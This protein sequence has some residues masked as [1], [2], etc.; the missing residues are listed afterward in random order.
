M[1]MRLASSIIEGC[2][3]SVVVFS[4]QGDHG[5]GP[6]DVLRIL[7][8]LQCN[9]FYSGNEGRTTEFSRAQQLSDQISLAIKSHGA[10]AAAELSPHSFPTP[11][12][13]QCPLAG[14]YLNLALIN[15]SCSPNCTKLTPWKEV[16]SA[17]GN[18]VG[19]WTASEVWATRNIAPGEELTISYLQPLEQTAPR[20]RSQFLEQ[21]LCELGPSPHPPEL[22]AFL[23]P[24][25]PE[26]RDEARMICPS[27]RYSRHPPEQRSR[28]SDIFLCFLFHPGHQTRLLA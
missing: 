8:A 1:T 23:H 27:F 6:D 15:H 13:N 11:N 5:L 28:R 12:F 26:N 19:S 20:R 9:A 22:E 25:S 4:K 21:H 17:A 3:L 18:G 16:R 14:L 7:L 2:C 24:P 10:A